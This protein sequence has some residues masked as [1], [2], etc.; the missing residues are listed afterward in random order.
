[1][2]T[3]TPLVTVRGWEWGPTLIAGMI[4]LHTCA[5]CVYAERGRTGVNWTAERKREGKVLQCRLR[6][7][8][9]ERT[10]MIALHFPNYFDLSP[11]F[12]G[13]GGRRGSPG[14]YGATIFLSPTEFR[15]SGRRPKLRFTVG[16]TKF[17]S[18]C[19]K[20]SYDVLWCPI[21]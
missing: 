3:F 14:I 1:M 10:G 16:I 17:Q 15:E 6:L 4:A 8:L 12:R 20:Y 13:G 9:D 11:F 2:S 21:Y 18:R 5:T 7:A 19:S